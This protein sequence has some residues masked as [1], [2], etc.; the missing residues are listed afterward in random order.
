MAKNLVAR[1]QVGWKVICSR[2]DVCK[3]P[4][5]ASTPPVPYPVYSELMTAGDVAKSV[6]SN[7]HPLVIL[8]DSYTP[9]TIGDSAG[10]AT[11][12]SSSTVAGKCYP[13]KASGTVRAEKHWLVRH[14][15]EFEMNAP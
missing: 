14:G 2:P 4:M 10:A 15:D 7:G 11:G 8:N 6:R 9:M 13:A 3:T 1:Q 5:G 12:V